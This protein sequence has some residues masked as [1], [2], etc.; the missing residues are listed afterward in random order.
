MARTTTDLQL[1]KIRSQMQVLHAKEKALLSKAN[2]KVIAQIVAL[3]EQHGITHEELGDA[4]GI[5][6]SKCSAKG[7]RNT[8]KAALKAVKTSDKR[9][10][11][12][13]KYRNPADGNQTW[14]GRG[15]SPTWIQALKAADTLESALIVSAN[16]TNQTN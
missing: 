11:V 8:E 16:Q 9:S 14:T 7:T 3:A 1:A 15:K 5:A 13:A 10:K 2:D 6:K 4:M 12:A